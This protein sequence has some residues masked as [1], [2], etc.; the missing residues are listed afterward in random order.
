MVVYLWG[1]SIGI[2]YFLKVFFICLNCWYVYLYFI[3]LWKR[4]D[5][6]I[7][8]WGEP[9]KYFLMDRENKHLFFNLGKHGECL[10]CV[11]HILGNRDSL[12]SK[13]EWSCFHRTSIHLGKDITNREGK[14][15][16]PEGHA[17]NEMEKYGT[18]MAEGTLWNQNKPPWEGDI[19]TD[20]KVQCRGSIWGKGRSGGGNS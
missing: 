11:G 15:R 5:R 3:A 17:R 12:V 16:G 18:V 20:P 14:I 13:T 19:S 4:S 6:E 2:R 10:L 1:E 8:I 9:G 7:D